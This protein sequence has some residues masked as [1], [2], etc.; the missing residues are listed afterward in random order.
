M[1][2]HLRNVRAGQYFA[3]EDVVGNVDAHEQTFAAFEAAPPIPVWDPKF[4]R[5]S[6]TL[7]RKTG[8]RVGLIKWLL[9]F[10]F[11]NSVLQALVFLGF[12]RVGNRLILPMLRAGSLDW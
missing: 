5:M 11:L 12:R 9:R 4:A 2:G 8:E 1:C 7:R 3:L 10:Y 6:P